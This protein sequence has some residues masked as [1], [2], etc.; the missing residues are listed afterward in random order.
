[1]KLSLSFFVVGILLM[2]LQTTFLHLLPLGPV[3]SDLILV[4]CVYWG[5]YQPTLGAALGVGGTVFLR[6]DGFW[7]DAIRYIFRKALVAA[8][9]AP[10]VF[11]LLRRGQAYLE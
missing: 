4:L 6:G 8:V 3:V 5:L 9:L 10:V 7:T 2:L 1:M 11:A